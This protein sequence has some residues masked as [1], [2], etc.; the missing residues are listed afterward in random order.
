[1]PDPWLT[2][3]ELK[4]H[5]EEVANHPL[6]EQAKEARELHEKDAE[7]ARKEQ[8][9][10]QKK[11]EKGELFPV[12]ANGAVVGYRETDGLGEEGSEEREVAELFQE[13]VKPKEDGAGG[14]TEGELGP[15]TGSEPAQGE[16]QS[17]PREAGSEDSPD[18]SNREV[19]AESRASAGGKASDN[20]EEEAKSSKKGSGSKADKAGKNEPK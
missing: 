15:V 1:M 9:E 3:D 18:A 19:Q 8:A 4:K 17:V 20:S 10:N 14:A 6:T 5:N 13:G 16:G 7:E 2:E 12:H 11:V